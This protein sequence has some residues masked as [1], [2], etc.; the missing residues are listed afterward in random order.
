M[1]QWSQIITMAQFLHLV[2]PHQVRSCLHGYNPDGNST[3]L[4][5]PDFWQP[6]LNNPSSVL[7][8]GCSV[9]TV[10]YL[11]SLCAWACP[12]ISTMVSQPTFTVHNKDSDSSMHTHNLP[13]DQGWEWAVWL[14]LKYMA[15]LLHL[16]SQLEEQ[17]THLSFA[18][19]RIPITA[20]G[21]H[22]SNILRETKKLWNK[23]YF[24]T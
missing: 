20:V 15:V 14:H 18:L 1:L 9:W 16:M 4:A 6:Q 22:H 13:W 7:L 21:T 2:L 8:Y 10:S 19:Y 5:L 17:E 12:E 24:V 3:L 11:K 23:S